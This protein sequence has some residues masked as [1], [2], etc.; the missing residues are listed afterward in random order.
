MKQKADIRML[1]LLKIP[2]N[3]RKFDFGEFVCY[4]TFGLNGK[5]RSE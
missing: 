4:N 1:I 5:E 2:Q 3:Q